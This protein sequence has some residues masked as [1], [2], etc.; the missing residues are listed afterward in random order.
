MP[1]Y[2]CPAFADRQLS[3]V[4][5]FV[6]RVIADDVSEAARRQQRDA[7]C[8]HLK[9]AMVGSDVVQASGPDAAVSNPDALNRRCWSQ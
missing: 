4:L 2:V 3:P 9:L 1:P 5:S 6:G 7:D 8:R